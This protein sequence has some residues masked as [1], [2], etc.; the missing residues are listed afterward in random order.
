ML[1]KMIRAHQVNPKEL[2]GISKALYVLELLPKVTKGIDVNVT[3]FSPKENDGNQSIRYWTVEIADLELH[4]YSGG[5]HYSEDVGGDTYSNFSWWAK[6]GHEPTYD[7]TYDHPDS[8][9]HE[10][11][12][13]DLVAESYGFDVKDNSK[14]FNMGEKS[15]KTN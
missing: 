11:Q 2:V 15:D 3:I 7:S 10:I 13:M 8:F 1:W 14:Q 9:L 12:S 4:I 5:C 6:P